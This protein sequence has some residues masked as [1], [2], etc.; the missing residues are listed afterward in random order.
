MTIPE[1]IEKV[2]AFDLPLVEV[3]G[4]EPLSQKGT[5]ELL[6]V[7]CE[8]RQDVL[9]ETSGAVDIGDVDPRVH[10]IM[11]IK[12]PDSQMSER[13]IWGNIDKL[14]PNHEIKFVIASKRDYDFAK[15]CIARYRLVGRAHLLMSPAFAL[16]D[17]QAVADWI[18]ADRLPV[19]YQLQLHK[20]IWDPKTKGV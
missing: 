3:T 6:R 16:I 2:L 1:I 8:K 14:L 12:C 11:D 18:L 5:I 15:N 9:L 7:L 4:G 13:M 17:R 10:I 20:F 19:R